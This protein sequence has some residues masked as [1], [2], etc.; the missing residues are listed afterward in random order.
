MSEQIIEFEADSLVKARE[1]LEAK[2]SEGFHILSER[3]IS[4]G[5][6]KTVQ[7]SADT[8]EA[9]FSK[10]QTEIPGSAE[11]IEKKE[12][13][14]PLHK[15]AI[16]KAFDEETAGTEAETMST[17]E[18]GKFG[19]FR[20]QH[21]IARGSK[22]FLGIGKKPHQYE[23]ELYREALIEIKYK[24]RARIS[25]TIIEDL[26]IQNRLRPLGNKKR[27]VGHS[28]YR[29]QF[30]DR[31]SA[32]CYY[33]SFFKYSILNPPPILIE[34]MVA[35]TP[36]TIYSEK[37]AFILPYFNSGAH[38]DYDQ[39]ARGAILNCNDVQRQHSYC[40]GNDYSYVTNSIGSKGAVIKWT[41]IPPK[42]FD[43]E[44]EQGRELLC[45]PPEMGFD[46]VNVEGQG[47][48]VPEKPNPS[49]PWVGVLFDIGKFDE[50]L[51]GRAAT[52]QLFAIVS[53]RQLSECVIHG[54]DLLPDAK[55][56]CNAI[57]TATQEQADMIETSIIKSGNEKLAQDRPPVIR[58]QQVP[59][60]SLPFQGFVSNDGIYV[61]V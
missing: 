38:E 51:Y 55:Y 36:N 57:H 27:L 60:N 26:A 40:S 46:V 3:I 52:K 56:W 20:S 29:A 18:L 28:D 12:L 19:K 2:K 30:R 23:V 5:T 33:E 21:L 58:G 17:K 54:G 35:Y 34:V 43:P 13:A 25:A 49:G 8:I 48:T 32:E 10:A 22:G 7:A 53:E 45:D 61:G 39:W 59:V 16:I 47:S 11:I 44:S 37:Y 4:D 6:P 1:Q 50:A 31:A 15:K 24:T 14:S 41:I 9:A 42:N